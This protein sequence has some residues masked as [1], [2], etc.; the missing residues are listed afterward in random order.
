M[1]KEQFFNL[2]SLSSTFAYGADVAVGTVQ[3]IP[4]DSE[5]QTA[6]TDSEPPS[7]WS[8]Q[9]IECNGFPPNVLAN[10]NVGHRLTGIVGTRMC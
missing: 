2:Q 5:A 10:K 8:R 6:Q 9:I 7:H 4:L 3:L 1:E